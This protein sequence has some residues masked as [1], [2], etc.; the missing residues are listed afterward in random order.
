M[1]ALLRGVVNGFAQALWVVRV[2]VFGRHVQVTHQHQTRVCSHFGLNPVVQ[3]LQPAH[4]VGELF[5]AGLLTIHK[6]AVEQAQR[7]FGGVQRGG[8]HTGLLVVKPRNVANHVAH[9]RAGQDGHAVVRLLPKR[10]GVVARVLQRSVR[11]LVIGQLQLLQAQGIHRVG[12][13]PGQHLGQTYR[14][15]VDVPGGN[16]HG[17]M[18]W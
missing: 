3:S 8:N 11:K 7:A 14:Q 1:V 18:W 2:A 17:W 9:R 15:G 4:L 5:R 16:F 6:V 12:G 10:H 13:Q